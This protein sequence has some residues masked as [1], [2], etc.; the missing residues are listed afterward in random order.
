M[1]EPHDKTRVPSPDTAIWR[2]VD[3]ANFVSMLDSG[4]LFFSSVRIL[5]DKWE[6]VFR[7]R[8]KEVWEKHQPR[9]NFDRLRDYVRVR[10]FV[11]CWHMNDGESDAMWKLYSR[12]GDNVAIRSTCE[13]FQEG[14]AGCK[15]K[16][17][18]GEVDYKNDADYDYGRV[19]DSAPGAA[20]LNITNLLLLWKRPSFEHER[21]VR[22]F[23]YTDSP[24][25]TTDGIPIPVDLN[26]LLDEIR[27]SPR[28]AKWLRDLVENILLKYGLGH[29][30]VRQSSMDD[31]PNP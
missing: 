28:S 10:A 17:H 2:Y 27:V 18:L 23:H 13:R 24:A 4:C 8:V 26:V 6:A 3:L 16:I 12:G 29:V 9:A 14:V 7:P 11:S 5:D 20:V 31:E 19:I 30:P 25:P 1:Y 21:E 15:E 22:A